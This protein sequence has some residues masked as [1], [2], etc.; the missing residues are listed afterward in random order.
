MDSLR[1]TEVQNFLFF[2]PLVILLLWGL[3]A[4]VRAIGGKR[5]WEGAVMIGLGF[6]T[7]AYIVGLGL[8]LYGWEF[9]L[10]VIAAPLHSGDVLLALIYLITLAIYGVGLVGPPA[11]LLR[12]WWRRTASRRAAH[13]QHEAYRCSGGS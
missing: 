9:I 4:A 12:A 8:W 10:T 2:T 3:V 11:L 7:T 6:A 5:R 13:W 1:A